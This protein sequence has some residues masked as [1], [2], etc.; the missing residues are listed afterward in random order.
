MKAFHETDPSSV[1]TILKDGL[2]CTSR[3]DK[4]D[5]KAIIKT[6]KLLDDCRPEHLRQ[7]GVSRDNNLYAF[8]ASGDNIIDITKGDML[9][10]DRFVSQ[11]RQ[12]VLKLQLNP[13]HCY[14]SD[15]DRY[16]RL[17]DSVE[18][19][20]DPEQLNHQADQY[21]QAL[22]P[23]TTFHSGDIRRPEI[24]VTYDIPPHDIEILR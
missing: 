3:G 20:A 15:L 12:T 13:K 2:Q 19:G 9:P 5:D 23:L 21:W 8:V 6:D 4:G 1:N 14:V 10:L 17:K 18:Q 7:A 22:A 24:M 16:D 11:S